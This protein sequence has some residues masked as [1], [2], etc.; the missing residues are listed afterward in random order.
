M[1][2]VTIIRIG[3]PRVRNAIDSTTAQRLCREFANIEAGPGRQSLCFTAT[4]GPSALAP[5][6]R[7]GLLDAAVV[8]RVAVST[9]MA[10][11]GGYA[12]SRRASSASIRIHRCRS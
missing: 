8:G 1:T 12:S 10:R 7:A 6:T 11:H 9:A 4:R 2:A 5:L 3:R